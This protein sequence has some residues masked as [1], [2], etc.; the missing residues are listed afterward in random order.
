VFYGRDHSSAVNTQPKVLKVKLKPTLS[1]TMAMKA[2]LSSYDTVA[3]TPVALCWMRISPWT[4]CAQRTAHTCMWRK[5][6]I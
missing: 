2:E 6:A 4:E 5:Q 3:T 1:P